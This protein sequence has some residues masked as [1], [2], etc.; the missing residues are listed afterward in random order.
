MPVPSCKVS[1]H[2]CRMFYA[3]RERDKYAVY[4]PLETTAGHK[5]G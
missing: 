2:Y 3:F 5:K 1:S 4:D